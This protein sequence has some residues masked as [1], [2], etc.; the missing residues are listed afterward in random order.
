MFQSGSGGPRV[1]LE[2][3]AARVF[4]LG[5][6]SLGDPIQGAVRDRS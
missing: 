5:A 2:G 3:R 4:L 1:P 6:S